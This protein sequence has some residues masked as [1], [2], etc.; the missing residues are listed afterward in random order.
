MRLPA[1]I[2]F[3][4]FIVKMLNVVYWCSLWRDFVWLTQ[5]EKLSLVGARCLH[6]NHP[7][8]IGRQSQL[9]RRLQGEPSPG[10]VASF[11][12]LKK[13]HLYKEYKKSSLR[14]VS[15]LSFST[16]GESA[17]PCPDLCAPFS[18]ATKT[19]LPLSFSAPIFVPSVKMVCSLRCLVPPFHLFGDSAIPISHV[20]SQF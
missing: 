7:E 11:A 6:E 3:L 19:L 2:L 5:E 4:Q 15:G 14:P 16:F 18:L 12:L 1:A 13:T 10:E 20:F 17:T 8:I 9:L